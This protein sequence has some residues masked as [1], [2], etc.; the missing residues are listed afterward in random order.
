M[1]VFGGI[2]ERGRGAY[3]ADFAPGAEAG[4][5]GG[6]AAEEGWVAGA[7]GFGCVPAG[8]VEGDV[9]R[10]FRGEGVPQLGV[11]L[12]DWHFGRVLFLS[13]GVG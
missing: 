12:F 8:D 7:E 1:G 13:C 5:D 6:E 10:R 4:V 9:V 3:L 11:D 2:W